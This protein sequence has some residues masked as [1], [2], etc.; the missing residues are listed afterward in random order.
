MYWPTPRGARFRRR[1]RV[2]DIAE[3][4]RRFHPVGD[5]QPL[6]FL[7]RL[8]LVVGIDGRSAGRAVEAPLG[9]V[10]VGIADGGT[11]VVEAHAVGGQCSGVGLDAYR[12]P[13]ATAETDQANAGE[14]RDFLRQPGINKV[15]YFRQRQGLRGDRQ[16]E[17][18]RI[19]RINFV[20]DRRHR[21]IGG[22]QV[23]GRVDCR[24]HLLLGDIQTQV[25]TEL[26]RNDRCAAGARRRHLIQSRHLAELAF[27]RRS[28]RRSHYFRARSRI[29]RDDLDGRVVDLRQCGQR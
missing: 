25:Q 1:R 18:G 9:L 23:A 17:N 10:H 8:E 29:E 11:H 22:Q 24:L 20:V 26:Q 2:G 3:A 27:Q 4:D 14:L 28:D 16:G 6:V 7:G 5:D 15:L 13:L 19:R 21:Q 12:R